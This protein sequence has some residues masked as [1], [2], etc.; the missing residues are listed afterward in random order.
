MKKLLTF[1]TAVAL[2]TALSACGSNNT[3]AASATPAASA[4][5]N[6]STVPAASG[7]AQNVTIVATNFTFDQKEYKVKA[8][9]SVN[10]TLDSKEGFHGVRIAAF[11]VNLNKNDNKATF[12]PDKPGTYDIICSVPCGAG[13]T[14]MKA[15]LIVE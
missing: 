9:Q 15:K 3:T 10:L 4:A 1:V 7:D 12:T 13:H 6:T 14:T 8:G 11:K 2:L 5:A